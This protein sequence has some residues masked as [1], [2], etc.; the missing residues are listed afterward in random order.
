MPWAGH[1]RQWR[2]FPLCNLGAA[3]TNE[4]VRV[5]GPLRGPARS[6]HGAMHAQEELSHL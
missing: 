1:Q 2:G 5:E 6:I 3:G 4:E